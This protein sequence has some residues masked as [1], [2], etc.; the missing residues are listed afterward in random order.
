MTAVDASGTRSGDVALSCRAV[1]RA[2]CDVWGDVFG[3]EVSPYDDFYELGGDSMTIIDVVDELS[4]RGVRVRSSVAL[5]HHT[6][7]RLAESL[8]VH[9]DRAPMP[10]PQTGDVRPQSWAEVR[11]RPTV[12]APDGAGAALV[13]LHSDTHPQRER[14]AAPAWR[15]GR[16]VVG[17]PAPGADGPLPAGADLTDIARHH[18][19][20][21]LAA[22]PHGPYPL[23]GFGLSAVVA[24]EVAGQLRRAGHEVPVLV[25]VEPPAAGPASGFAS[26]TA[27]LLAL[28]YAALGRRFALSGSESPEEVLSRVREEGWYD[29]DTSPTDLSRLQLAWADLALAVRGY[30]PDPHPGRVVLCLDEANAPTAGGYWSALVTDPVVH[31]FDYG[32]ESPAPV[33][34]DARLAALVRAEL[35][36]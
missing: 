3:V 12:V 25:M 31:L 20:A 1:E 16:P 18:V 14:E 8:T 21:V 10:V 28:R 30:E 6:P 9:A 17:I 5:R 13:L 22:R 19:S 35:A 29:V 24:F 4:R 26:S 27:D 15:A 34:G 32:V 23:V 33:I 2:V 7:A 36:R 11:R